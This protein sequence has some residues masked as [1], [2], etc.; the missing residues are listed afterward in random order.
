[1]VAVT[2]WDEPWFVAAGKPVGEE[3]PVSEQPKS[4]PEAERGPAG[5]GLPVRG[6]KCSG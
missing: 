2:S 3:V 6:L 5:G 4:E 1:M